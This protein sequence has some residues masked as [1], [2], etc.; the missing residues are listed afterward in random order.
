MLKYSHIKTHSFKEV[1]TPSNEVY[2]EL[3]MRDTVFS[4]YKS[5]RGLDSRLFHNFKCGLG[6]E[7]DPFSL[8]RTIG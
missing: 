2:F 7:Q 3:V 6:L 8:V 4:V 5:Y 1:L